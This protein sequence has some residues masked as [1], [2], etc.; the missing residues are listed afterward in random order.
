MIYEPLRATGA[1]EAEQGLLDLF[2]IRLQNHDV[3]DSDV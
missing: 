2:T 3:Q 1:C